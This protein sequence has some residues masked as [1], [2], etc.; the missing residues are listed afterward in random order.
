MS[1]VAASPQ[2]DAVEVEGPR[3]RGIDGEE[4][5]PADPPQVE[6]TPIGGPLDLGERDPRMIR[7]RPQGDRSGGNDLDNARRGAN[8]RSSPPGPAP[9]PTP[10]KYRI[11]NHDIPSNRG[12]ATPGSP[13][14]SRPGPCPPSGSSGLRSRGSWTARAGNPGIP[15]AIIP[16]GL[17][18]RPAS[19]RR[20]PATP[21]PSARARAAPTAR[22]RGSPR[23][24]TGRSG[25]RPMRPSASIPRSRRRPPPR[26]RPGRHA[27]SRSCRS[28]PGGSRS[29]RRGPRPWP[30]RP[31][32]VGEATRATEIGARAGSCSVKNPKIGACARS[33]SA[34]DLAPLT[35]HGHEH[36]PEDEGGEEPRPWLEPHHPGQTGIRILREATSTGRP[37]GSGI[38]VPRPGRPAQATSPGTGKVG[39]A[40]RRDSRVTRAC[41]TKWRAASRAEPRQHSF[42]RR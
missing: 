8:P 16:G 39:C 25:P 30:R 4:L 31:G 28:G 22:R 37:G 14:G 34:R 15:T 27:S 20:G 26:H 2:P 41:G 38:G 21:R 13:P 3:P 36:A 32:P 29:R 24:S 18:T 7:T 6:S 40:S 11:P 33:E 5:E 19:A 12:P 1:I 10:G 35:R 42:S 9:A 17:R 23:P